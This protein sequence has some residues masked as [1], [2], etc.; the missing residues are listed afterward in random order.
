[1]PWEI[2]LASDTIAHT[3]YSK[4][5]NLP[6]HSSQLIVSPNLSFGVIAFTCGAA[7]TAMSLAMEA[8]KVIT[9]L[10]QQVLGDRVLEAYAGIYQQKCFKRRPGNGEIVIEVDIDVMITRMVDCDGNDLFKM[11]DGRCWNEEC[12]AKLWPVGRAGE[13]RFSLMARSGLN[14]GL[15]FL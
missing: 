15:K 13:F 4:A 10:M 3:L 8:E 1:M 7:S 5:G 12:F 14:V 2:F 11:F 6:G 9:P